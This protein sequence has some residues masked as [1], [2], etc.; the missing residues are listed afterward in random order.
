MTTVV[1]REVVTSTHLYS[2]LFLTEFMGHLVDLLGRNWLQ[3]RT[4]L[5]R[6]S[7][8]AARILGVEFCRAA[9]LTALP[10]ASS[11]ATGRASPIGSADS[12]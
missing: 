12:A 8:V 2:C 6:P 10:R 1:V 7:L 5:A 3:V 4:F 11:L 9:G